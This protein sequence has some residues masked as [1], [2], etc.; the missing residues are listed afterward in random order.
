MQYFKF[1]SQNKNNSKNKKCQQLVPTTN[2]K[3]SDYKMYSTSILIKQN[4]EK[5]NEVGVDVWLKQFFHFVGDGNLVSI[6]TSCTIE[7]RIMK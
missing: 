2:F 7:Q 4:Y 5:Q 3:T 1:R 6:L